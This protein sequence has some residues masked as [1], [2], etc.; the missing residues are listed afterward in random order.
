MMALPTT[1][2]RRF[3]VQRTVQLLADGGCH[4]TADSASTLRVA[5]VLWNAYVKDIAD[6]SAEVASEDLLSVHKVAK[7]ALTECAVRCGVST[8]VQLCQ[9]AARAVCALQSALLQHHSGL[10][11]VCAELPA[12]LD[13]LR[14]KEID[15]SEKSLITASFSYFS[16]LTTVSDHSSS[17]SDSIRSTLDSAC[18]EVRKACAAV[19][20]SNAGAHARAAGSNDAL[21]SLFHAVAAG[22]YR[23]VPALGTLDAAA[24]MYPT[25]AA[26]AQ[27]SAHA[28]HGAE[29]SMDVEVAADYAE[30]DGRDEEDAQDGSEGSAGSDMAEDG[31][32][33][34]DEDSA[35]SSADED[36]EEGEGG[37]ASDSDN[38]RWSAEL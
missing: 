11:K 14:S 7:D 30:E 4:L 33:G 34:S 1:L 19:A 20:S 17:V 26:A 18:A 21:A 5:L 16:Q 15:S 37:N 25:I 36:E 23:S 31:E 8:Q 28:R 29:D 6:D 9:V 12:A 13:S 32:A 2:G 38:S 27:R 22:E 3:A 10:D 24:I 35:G